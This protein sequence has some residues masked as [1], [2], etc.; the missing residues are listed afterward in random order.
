MSTKAGQAHHINFVTAGP[1]PGDADPEA[2][3]SAEELAR[4][5]ERGEYS[6]NERGYSAIMRTKPQTIG[7]ALNDSPV[8]Q[9]AWI[10]DKVRWLCDRGADPIRT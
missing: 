4:V 8:G 10:V 3:V 2:G 1:P 9:A 7:L 5:R 6:A